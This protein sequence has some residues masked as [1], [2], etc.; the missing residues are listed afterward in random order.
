[1]L[2]FLHSPTLTSIHDHWETIALTR[3]IFVGK[4]MPLLF[5]MLSRLVIINLLEWPKS[6][7]DAKC[8][9]GH[10]ATG[11]FIH[12]WW[13][14]KMKQSLHKTVVWFAT[15][16]NILLPYQPDIVPLGIYPK[17]LKASIHTKIHTHIY[18]TVLFTIAK[19]WKQVRYSSLGDR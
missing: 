8:W 5:N 16:L 18:I 7:D 13:K 3:Q 11:T 9:Y 4:V 1:M 10:E 6:S 12:C 14:C 2:S 17:K 15:K 19:T